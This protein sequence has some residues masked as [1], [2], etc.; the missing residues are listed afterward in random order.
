MWG[1]G[2]IKIL[3]RLIILTLTLTLTLT[4]PIGKG[5]I[6]HNVTNITAHTHWCFGPER[7]SFFENVFVQCPF[8]ISLFNLIIYSEIAIHLDLDM[9]RFFIKRA[10]IS[11][12]IM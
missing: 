6:S 7:A 8:L 4:A 2:K 3:A 5:A 12:G 10:L 11:V 9:T 1:S